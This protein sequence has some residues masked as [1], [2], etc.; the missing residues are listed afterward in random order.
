MADKVEQRIVQLSFSPLDIASAYEFLKIPEAGGIS[1]FIG[2]TRRW[3]NGKETISLS[4]ESY[5]PMALKEMHRLAKIAESK[6][7]IHQICIIHRL[8]KVPVAEAS[9]IVGVSTSHRA[10]AFQACR[11]LID[12]LKVQ[13]PIWKQEYLSDGSKS[14]VEGTLPTQNPIV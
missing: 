11:F 5:Q 3:T 6:W 7:P 4:Y 13:V 14:W 2:T 8:G 10:E 9:V 12:R 1:M